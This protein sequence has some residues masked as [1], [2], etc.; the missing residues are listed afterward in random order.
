MTRV[1]LPLSQAKQDAVETHPTPLRTLTPAGTSWL[2][3]FVPPSLVPRMK[4]PVASLP[5]IS[6]TSTDG[7]V[8][9]ADASLGTEAG[10]VLLVQ[11]LPPSLEPSTT[12]SR[13]ALSD[14]I[15][16]NPVDTTQAIEPMPYITNG[17]VLAVHLDPAFV[18]A[19]RA[20]SKVNE[21]TRQL[22]VAVHAMVGNDPCE[23]TWESPQ[24]SPV[25]TATGT[26]GL[27][28]VRG[29]NPVPTD[30]QTPAA[31]QVTALRS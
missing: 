15:W 6:Q 16:Q 30:M 26:G 31:G 20:L 23:A 9:V 5:T 8:T 18:V 17:R 24:P 28:G 11:V 25:P 4:V 22:V 2:V 13:L 27:F 21:E 29:L 14:V 1:L 12:R 3:H 10:R 7:Q 19:S